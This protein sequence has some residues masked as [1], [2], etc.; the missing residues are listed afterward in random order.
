M[1][2]YG[3]WRIAT[4]FLTFSLDG[5]RGMY[6]GSVQVMGMHGIYLAPLSI[7]FVFEG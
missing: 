1:K 4:S 3:K 2:A 5:E 6:S 7:Y